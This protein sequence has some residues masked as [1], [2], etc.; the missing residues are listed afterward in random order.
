LATRIKQRLIEKVNNPERN[1]L[2]IMLYFKNP[3]DRDLNIN[4]ETIL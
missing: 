3:E 1:G 2:A 4:I